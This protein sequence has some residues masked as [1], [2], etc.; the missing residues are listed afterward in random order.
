ML[1]R[2]KR[3]TAMLALV[4]AGTIFAC[5][6]SAVGVDACQQIQRARCGWVV[7]CPSITLPTRRSE[8]T[9]PVDDCTRYYNDQCLHGL[10]TTVA[11]SQGEVQACVD[12]INAA[13]SCDIV[14]AP[15][16]SSACA[17]LIPVDAGVDASDAKKD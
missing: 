11:P 6:Q 9:S 17:F 3:L 1:D 4:G 15:E 2:A 14:Y 13:T 16:T 7:E 5:G 8:S 10:V 12:A